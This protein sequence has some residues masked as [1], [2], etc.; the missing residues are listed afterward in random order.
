MTLYTSIALRLVCIG[1]LKLFSGQAEQSTLDVI[2]FGPG[3]L[4]MRC[5]AAPLFTTTFILN[6]NHF[7]AISDQNIRHSFDPSSKRGEL[8]CFGLQCP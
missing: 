4:Q 5:S 2:G 7:H 8:D 1:L 3:E 6:P